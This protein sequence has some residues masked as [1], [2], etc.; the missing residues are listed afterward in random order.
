MF[1]TFSLPGFQCIDG[2]LLTGA[3]ATGT[4]ISID[5]FTKFCSRLRTEH[6]MHMIN[7]MILLYHSLHYRTSVLFFHFCAIHLP[8]A[9]EGEFLLYYV[10]IKYK[11]AKIPEEFVLQG[12]LLLLIFCMDYGFISIFCPSSVFRL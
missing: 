3:P 7:V 2:L 8:P 10:K 4:F 11:V 12:F 6:Y 9:E 5:K 1:N